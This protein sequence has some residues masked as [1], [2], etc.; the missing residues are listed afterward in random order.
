MTEETVLFVDFLGFGAFSARPDTLDEAKRALTSIAELLRPDS[1]FEAVGGWTHRYAVS[2]S[3]FLTHPDPVRA[4]CWATELVQKVVYLSLDEATP[5][6]M[7][8]GLAYGG[9][10]HL[11]SA[12]VESADP[13][14]VIG[15]AVVAAAKLDEVHLKG[16]RLFVT[17]DLVDLIRAEQPS[18]VSWL[19]RPTSLYR[20]WEVLWLLPPS[21]E[22]LTK[23]WNEVSSIA[24]KA[25]VLLDRQGGNPGYGKHYRGFALLAARCVERIARGSRK[26]LFSQKLPADPSTLLPEARLLEILDNRSGIPREDSQALRQVAAAVARHG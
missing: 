4:L 3:V 7:R 19:L 17:E 2:D 25:M 20:V 26:D 16:P 1:P 6:L 12:V 15:P 9:V 8:G 21:P 24:D 10:E 5:V 23:R 22:G 18:L 11:R 13:R 14:N